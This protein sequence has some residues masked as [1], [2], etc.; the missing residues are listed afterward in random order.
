MNNPMFQSRNRIIAPIYFGV[1]LLIA[2]FFLRPAYAEY[3]EKAVIK[4]QVESQKV[5]LSTELTSLKNIQDNIDTILSQDKIDIINK[6]A[7]KFNVSDIMSVVLFNEYTK[8]A[9]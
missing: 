1:G 8:D 6:L 5:T 7:K 9:V 3:I 2:I 4:K